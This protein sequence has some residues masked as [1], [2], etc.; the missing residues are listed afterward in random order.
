MDFK[1][2]CLGEI[3]KKDKRKSWRA[4]IAGVPKGE[5]AYK[6]ESVRHHAR[7]HKM[8]INVEY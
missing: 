1:T 3:K 8:K 6:R 7:Q 2:I 5:N 4:M